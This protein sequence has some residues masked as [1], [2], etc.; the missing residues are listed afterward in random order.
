MMKRASTC[1]MRL[2]PISVQFDFELILDKT[3]N[4]RGQSS[5]FAEASIARELVLLTSM[6]PIVVRPFSS[7][8]QEFTRPQHKSFQ[9]GFGRTIGFV[10]LQLL[11]GY[12]RQSA[13]A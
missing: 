5:P 4:A 9:L 2:V 7:S 10:Y 1:Q 3:R 11:C 12:A 8:V 6:L 13:G